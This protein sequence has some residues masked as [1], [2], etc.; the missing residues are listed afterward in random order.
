MSKEVWIG[1]AANAVAT[2]IG[3]LITWV[4]SFWYFKRA[5]DELR[6]EATQ[7]RTLTQLALVVLTDPKGNYKLKR[8]SE[9]DITGLIAELSG[10]SM[11]AG[12]ARA[13]STTQQ[14][15]SRSE[16]SE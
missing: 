9:G 15:P 7:L 8:D 13:A 6:T 10:R 2:V 5:G 14:P 4:A 3:G 12:T 1:I 11:A 16:I